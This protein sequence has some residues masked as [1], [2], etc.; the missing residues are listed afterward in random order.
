[1]YGLADLYFFFYFERGRGAGPREV[2]KRKSPKHCAAARIKERSNSNS[3]NNII[4]NKTS[5]LA[6]FYC[7]MIHV[8]FA[9]TLG[10]F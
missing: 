9:R 2:I 6:D 3:S 5:L 8:I 7:S 4:Q 1:M 10:Y